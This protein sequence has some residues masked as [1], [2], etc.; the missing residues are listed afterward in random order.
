VGFED[1]SE[2]PEAP[3]PKPASPQNASTIWLGT[4]GWSY[5]PDW[6]GSFYPLGT[7]SSE[8]LARYVEAFRFVEVDSTFYAAPART[9]IQ[10]WANIFPADFRASFKAPKELVQ[11]T[12]LRP[13]EV[14]FGHFC[15]ALR[16]VLQERLAMIVV[17]MPPSFV[18]SAQTE[19]NLRTFLERWGEEFPIAI[20][21]RDMS[22][23]RQAIIE[24]LRAHSVSMVSHDVHD[25]PDLDKA[26]FD[27]KDDAA[28]IRLIGRH[29]GMSKDRIQRPQTEARAWWI[30][31]VREMVDRGVKNVFIVVNNHY[32]GHAPQTLRTLMTEL[33]EAQLEPVESTG[34]PGGQVSLF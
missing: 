27:T 24:M 1:S 32:E 7:S 2:I 13:P 21:F 23:R 22:W 4:A 9:T 34:W 26:A 10:R 8:T 29:D 17:Q 19:T 16:E 5:L 20:E 31:R 15:G 30:Q 28:Y 6:A 11:E 14:P 12:F 25:Y 3:G 33:K 18:R